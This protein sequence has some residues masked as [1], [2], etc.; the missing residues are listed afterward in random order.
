MPDLWGII[1]I[2][3]KAALYLGVLTS[4]GTAFAAYMIG[5]DL[6]P[7]R[8]IALSFAILGLL[9]SVLIFCLRGITL[10]GDVSGMTDPEILGLLWG[11]A[12]GTAL[13]LRLAG[14]G[15]L[16]LGLVLPGGFVTLAAIGGLVAVGSFTQV[17][18]VSRYDTWWLSAL[19]AIHLVG[20][21][22]WIGVLIPLRRLALTKGNLWRAAEVG[23]KFGKTALMTVPVL[24]AAGGYM[25]YTLV[26]T[27]EALTTTAYG[28]AI[29]IKVA[30][31]AVLLFFAAMN[32]LRFVPQ[33]RLGNREAAES[34]ARSISR[35]WAVIG[36]II[37]VTAVL[38]SGL[39]LPT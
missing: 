23:D 31:V 11:S 15:I 29:V 33:V 3:T 22:F 9:A 18:H 34:L 6:G 27:V 19:L 4:C 2:I 13:M 7:Y 35:E 26:G 30:L 24:I 12:A 32:K 14:L 28:Q 17:G 10:T 39:T 1:E 20:V 16:I 36:G 21:A 37:V 5:P 25:G 8:R 38:T